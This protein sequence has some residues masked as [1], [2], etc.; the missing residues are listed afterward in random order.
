MT[1]AAWSSPRRGACP[2][3][4]APMPTGDGLLVRLLPTATIS[5]DAF[6]A[7]CAAAQE[8]GNGVIEITA[9]GSI[10]V[11]GLS[12]ASA[13]RFA[14]TITESGIAATDGVPVLTSALAGL[15]AAE[16]L[17]ASELA[18]ALRQALAR[19]SLPAQL[20]PKLSVVIDGGG[21][22]NLDGLAADLRLSAESADGEPAIRI[23]VAGDRTG[24]LM[25]GAVGPDHAIEVALLLLDIICRSGHGARARDIVGADGGA[26]FRATIADFLIPDRPPVARG[27]PTSGDPI[28]HH[29]LRDGT[30]ARG[31]GIAF[32]HA[33]AAALTELTEA[34]AS[35]GAA[36]LRAAPGRALLIAGLSPEASSS[37][38]ATAE[39]R[40]FVVRTDDPRRF[41]FACAGAP[42]CSSA[43]IAARALAP[44]LSD[45]AGARL[46]PNFDLHISGCAK[47]CAHP[48]AAA[49]TIVGTASGCALIARGTARSPHVALVAPE[50]LPDA[51]GHYAGVE[52]ED[53]HV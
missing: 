24:A 19:T 18:D 26:A 21:A 12:A 38:A 13:V 14:A 5:P 39:S 50:E 15:D 2:G 41:V 34:A 43:H 8:H 28:G 35:A 23:G 27:V 20:A 9:R 30:C 37:L 31:F 47:G 3:L 32:G 40:G 52:D 17:D 44:R 49:L 33:T 29:P 10:Q 25:L 53:Q 51:V 1:A 46:G 22:L 45:I 36:S 7:L 48:R 16:L 42:I 4:S 11:R 6:R